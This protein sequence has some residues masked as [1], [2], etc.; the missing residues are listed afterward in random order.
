MFYAVVDHEELVPATQVT[1][2]FLSLEEARQWTQ[3]LED[4]YPEVRC[5]AIAPFTPPADYTDECAVAEH[6]R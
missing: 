3:A 2:P 4:R 5:H 1:G 6:H